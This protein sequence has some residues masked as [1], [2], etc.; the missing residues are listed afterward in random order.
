M[1]IVLIYVDDILLTGS[2]SSVIKRLISEL[3]NQFALKD[4]GP[5]QF[6]LGIEAHRTS[7]VLHLSQSKYMSDLLSKTALTDCKSVASPM[8]S[9]HTLSLHEGVPLDN[10]TLYRSIVG[11]L[12]YCTLTRPDIS[13]AVNKVCQFICI[14]PLKPIGKL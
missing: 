8:A 3:H 9:D 14:N 5:L 7:S 11:G 4:L 6:F 13:F 10:P 12:P 1:L 2:D